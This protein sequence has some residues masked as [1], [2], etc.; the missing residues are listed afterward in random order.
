MVVTCLP[1][2]HVDAGFYMNLVMGIGA[3]CGVLT[4]GPG[5]HHQAGTAKRMLLYVAQRVPSVGKAC[6]CNRH[7]PAGEYLVLVIR[8]YR[9][10]STVVPVSITRT[11]WA[12]M[13][14][15]SGGHWFCTSAYRDI[16]A[17]WLGT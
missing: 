15:A 17:K 2:V 10:S 8:L 12:R 5:R 11:E 9:E 16:S 3:L 13:R 1:G 14:L 6:S 4:W 7:G